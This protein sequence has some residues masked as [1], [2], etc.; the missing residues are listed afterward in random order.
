MTGS[1]PLPGDVVPD[2]LDQPFWDACRDHQLLVHRCARCGTSYWP[3]SCCPVDG[4]AY[5][6]WVPATGRGRIHTYTIV[7]H[8]Y[9]RTFR[10]V[11]YNIAVVRLDEGPLFHTS[12]VE[13]DEIDVG[14]EVEVV[15]HDTEERFTLPL[16]RPGSSP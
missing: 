15:F 5:M 3:A 8:V 9:G 2:D 14:M 16:F 13:C 1:R 12:I 7:H 6:E 11:P 4:S 10:E